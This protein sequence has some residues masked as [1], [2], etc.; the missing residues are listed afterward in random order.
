ML[1]FCNVQHNPGAIPI[2]SAN[3]TYIVTAERFPLAMNFA[4]LML[5]NEEIASPIIASSLPLRHPHLLAVNEETL[6]TCS[7]RWD[8]S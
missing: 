5:R 8:A 1:W 4:Q 6:A 3:V 7:Q 2:S